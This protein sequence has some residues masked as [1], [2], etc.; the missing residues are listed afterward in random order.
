MSKIRQESTE[1]RKLQLHNL[2]KQRKH[3]LTQ[4]YC[5]SRLHEFLTITDDKDL[6]DQI[7]EFLDLNDIQKGCVFDPSSLPKFKQIEPPVE[8]KSSR[9]KSSTPV[10]SVKRERE[11]LKEEKKTHIEDK[12]ETSS[13][14]SASESTEEPPAKRQKL[15]SK[16]LLKVPEIRGPPRVK[17]LPLNTYLNAT[18]TPVK[19]SQKHTNYMLKEIKNSDTHNETE[20][21]FHK[22]NINARDSVYLLMNDNIPSKIPQ[23]VPLAELKYVSQTLPL[24]K[25]IPMAHKAVTT[26]IMNTALNEGRIA[27]V[28]SRI[29]ELKRLGLWS[30]RQPKKF[31]DPWTGKQH[32]THQNILIEEGKWMQADFREFKKYKIAICAMM[33]QAVMDYWNYGKVCCVKREE[34]KHSE[35]NSDLG[36]ITTPEIRD[37]AENSIDISLLMKRIDPLE[38]IKPLILP[39]PSEQDYRLRV[40]KNPTP[41]KLVLSFDELNSLERS[42]AQDIPLYLGVQEDEQAIKPVSELPFA[43]IS[44]STVLLDDDNYL[45]LVEKQVIEEE[46]SLVALS[47]RRGMFYGNRRSHYLRPP[48]APSL[49]YL[50][51]RTPTIWLPEDDQE[52][53]KNIN[54]YAYNWELIS[55]HLSS[56]STRAYISNI[57]RRTPWQCFE[58]FVQLNEKFQFPDMKGPKAH[59]AQIWLIEAHRLQQQQK[60]RISPLGVGEESIQRGHE[61]LR[62]A[63]MFEAM[64]KCIKKRENAPRPN[65][66]QPRKPLDCKN[67]AVP[68]PAEMSQLKAQRDDALRRDLQMRRVAKQRLAAAVQQQQQQQQNAS[69]STTKQQHVPR[70]APITNNS[71]PGSTSNSRQASS[72]PT[73]EEAKVTTQTPQQRPVKQL[74]EKEIIESYARKILAQKP[75]FT[76]ELALKAA[77]SYYRNVTLKQQQN[78]KVALTAVA[79]NNAKTM[80]SSTSA[81]V[82]TAIRSPTPQE[83]LQK[84]Q[85]QKR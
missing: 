56:Q 5:V 75:D 64:R 84:F 74:T 66:T 23:A 31:I 16:D 18:P 12:K 50:Q 11:T 38:E 8:R 82:N 48:V 71:R 44:K 76:P 37:D 63:S 65:P 42:I 25:L 28:S 26:D 49:R 67:T 7:E 22:D 85:Q 69:R 40:E 59:N 55:A 45:K 81:N 72:A 24:I 10:D 57:E 41:F 68:T 17:P 46:P 58:R 6:T 79:Q 54:A 1:Q 80:V 4:L 34:I 9:S 60:R 39:T 78:A 19:V 70:S 83:L 13:A 52:L 43:P 21:L 61:R 62:W 3:K 51:Y 47:K 35:E 32:L 15:E 73:T 30:L 2:L 36:S 14:A 33:A 27:V 20:M 77:E 53:V 29:E